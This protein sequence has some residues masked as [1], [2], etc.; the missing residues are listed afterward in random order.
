MFQEFTGL[1][2][3]YTNAA[4]RWNTAEFYQIAK[5]YRFPKRCSE[6]FC[7]SKGDEHCSILCSEGQYYIRQVPLSAYRPLI[8]H[9]FF[10][11]RCLIRIRLRLI[12]HS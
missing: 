4:P 11:V 12:A 1:T 5:E 8:Y 10:C 7:P 2:D 6:Q 9:D 3:S